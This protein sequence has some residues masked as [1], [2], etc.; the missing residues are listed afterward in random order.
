MKYTIAAVAAMV[1]ALSLPVS[2][3]ANEPAAAS[4]AAQE[5]SMDNKSCP[6]M[7]NMGAMK[8][9]MKSMRRE[10][11]GMMQKM[12]DPA[13]K[14]RMQKMHEKMGAMMQDMSDMQKGIDDSGY[15]HRHKLP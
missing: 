3:Q 15:H 12:S 14:E 2:V 11:D 10:M 1:A 8:K 7:E 9:D 5:K 13:M 4:P 6:M